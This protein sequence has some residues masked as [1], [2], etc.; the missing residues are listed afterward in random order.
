MK[1]MPGRED[2]Q[3]TID[4][5][6][7]GGGEFAELFFESSLTHSIICEDSK[8]ERVSSGMDAGFGLRVITGDRTAY[9][10]SNIIDREELF[11]LG[12]SVL[13][14][15]GRSS[16]K[17]VTLREISKGK[18][19]GIAR[20]ADSVPMD[21]KVQIVLDA[22]RAA[23]E[24]GKEI[25]QIQVTYRDKLQTVGIFNN[26]GDAIEDERRQVIFIVRAVATDGNDLQTAYRT[27]GGRVG[28]EL[29]G[30]EK[31]EALAAEAGASAIKILHARRS[32]AGSMTVV[33]A[34][35]A[36]GTMIHEAIGHGLEGDTAEKS[37]S[38]YSGNV[39]EMVASPLITVVDDATMEGKRGSFCF[40]DEGVAAQRTVPVENGVLKGYLLDRL[41][42][43]KLGLASTGNG[44][45]E[46]Y[47]YRP[48]VRMSNTMIAAGEHDPREI[49]ASVDS[50][51]YVVRMGGGQVNTSSG[52]FVFKVNEAYL[53]KGGKVAEPVRGAT[54]VGNGPAILRKID[55]VGS[56]LGFDI[57]TCGKDGQHVPVADAQ[58]TLRIPAI[59]VGGEV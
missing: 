30:S 52:D 41:T 54:L 6:I 39:G 23:R 21:E 10:Y 25:V 12:R 53:I 48:I 50:G 40:D 42:A 59:T 2:I 47:R 33:L 1:V 57:G 34:S 51:L 37:L 3:A 26:E 13:E 5:V 8:V 29:F 35:E 36:G 28:F 4:F 15:L 43:K 7:S 58:P 44:R 49:I 22:D 20:P 56:D 11:R 46:S 55:M 14:E 32:P 38:I 17:T 18:T 9:G 31:P 45:R 16:G 19:S 24:A 27:A